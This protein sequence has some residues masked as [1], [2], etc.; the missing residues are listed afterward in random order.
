VK[1]PKKH[2]KLKIYYKKIYF[3]GEFQQLQ[4]QDGESKRFQQYLSK[5]FN[6]TASLIA[7]SCKANAVLAGAN[8]EMV[9]TLHFLLNL[10]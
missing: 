5:T 8:Q 9:D 6:K 4:T 1:T 3:L 2:F 7:H 10:I